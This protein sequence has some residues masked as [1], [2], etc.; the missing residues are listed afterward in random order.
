MS[1]QAGDLLMVGTDC[2]DSGERPRAR[3]GDTVHIEAAGFAPLK[4]TVIS[5]LNTE[6]TA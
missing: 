2:L 3:A 6:G 5:A 1:L 4:Q